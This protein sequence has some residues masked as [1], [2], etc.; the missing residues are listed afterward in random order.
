MNLR[1]PILISLIL[2]VAVSGISNAGATKTHVPPFN[3][4]GAPNSQELKL[5]LQEILTSRLNPALVQLVEK[6]D[7]ADLLIVGSYAQFGKMFSLDARIKDTGSDSLT[8]VFEQGEG[9]EDVIPAIGRLALKING[10]VAK[11]P[12]LVVPEATKPPLPVVP[13]PTVT[14]PPVAK[15]TF[16]IR[17]E[18]S[19]KKTTDGWTSAPLDGVFSSLAV[20][21]T[22]AGGDRELFVAGEH[23]IQMYLKGSGLKLVSEITV[24]VPARIIAIDTADLNRDGLPEL[25]VSIIDRG[26]LASRVYQFDGTTFVMTAERLPWFFRGMGHDLTSRTIYTQEMVGAGK[27]YGEVKELSWTGGSYSTQ[28]PLKLPRLGNIFNFSRLG[29][30]TDR[31]QYVVLDG[32]GYL[33]VFSSDGTEVWKSSDKFGGSESAIINE[34]QSQ[35][36]ST[37]GLQR[38]V[39]LEQR[40]QLLKDG[41]LLVPYNEGTFS[42]GNNRAFNKHTLFAFEWTGT[43][44][45]EKWH[46]RKLPSYLA[47]YAFD[48]TTGEVVQ[49]EVVQKPGLFTAGK[50]ALSITRID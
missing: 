46:S 9:Q 10:E 16:A 37:G 23:T 2:S 5:T 48:Q 39:F 25:Y 38:W 40:M 33:V 1:L 43:V 31:A 18:P 3:V 6:P 13:L 20:G 27:Y 21:R 47:D 28:N 14:S 41:T 24:P 49:L 7:Q 36:H 8:K 50:S 35:V 17:S 45:K 26:A 32:D 42:I 30:A 4:S 44:L 15:E 19:A 34:S 11:R 12:V 22:L 29:G